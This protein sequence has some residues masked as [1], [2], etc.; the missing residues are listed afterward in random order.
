MSD[1]EEDEPPAKKARP[2]AK[3]AKMVGPPDEWTDFLELD[4]YPQPPGHVRAVPCPPCL[5]CP[6]PQD[7]KSHTDLKDILRPYHTYTSDVLPM[8]GLYFLKRYT[9][10]FTNKQGEK[11]TEETHLFDKVKCA[12]PTIT[13]WMVISITGIPFEESCRRCARHDPQIPICWFFRV[14]VVVAQI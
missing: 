2:E 13:R 11:M 3:P 14:R 6:P 1:T 12:Y 4:E 7:A 5:T 8:A 9:R 10:K